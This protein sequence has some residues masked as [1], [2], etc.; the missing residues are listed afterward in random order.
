MANHR[1]FTQ[2]STDI[3]M[4]FGRKTSGNYSFGF[5][6]QGF[7]AGSPQAAKNS[8]QLVWYSLKDAVLDV[9]TI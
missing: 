7:A 9:H 4:Y 1:L 6:P 2:Y 3:R 8:T 5:G